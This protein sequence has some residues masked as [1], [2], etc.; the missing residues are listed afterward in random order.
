MNVEVRLLG[1]GD[2]AVLDNVADDVFDHD[3]IPEQAAR[4]LSDPAHYLAVAIVD[5][6]VVGMA[7][8]NEYLHPDKPVM[9]WVNEMGVCPAWQRQGI[10]TQLLDALLKLARDNGFEEIW[11]GTENDNI[12]ARGLYHSLGG[13][14]EQFV[15]YS[16]EFGAQEGNDK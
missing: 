14:E 5:G 12:P 10:G 4:F 1:P 2:E 8:A 7:S 13:K 16:W 15:M 6:L 11:L 3:I 9:I